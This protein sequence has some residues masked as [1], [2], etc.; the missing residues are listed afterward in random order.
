VL[1]KRLKDFLGSMGTPNSTIHWKTGN[2]V[3]RYK[4]CLLVL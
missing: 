2:H 3:G 1:K 4:S